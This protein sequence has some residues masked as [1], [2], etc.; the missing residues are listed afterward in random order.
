[1]TSWQTRVSWPA[2]TPFSSMRPW[3]SLFAVLAL[4]SSALAADL[5]A[6]LNNP[7]L[8][9]LSQTDFEKLPETRGF[10]WTSV[11]HDSAR[12]TKEKLFGLPVVEVIARFESGKLAALTSLFYGRGDEGG[13][14]EPQ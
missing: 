11:A 4:A 7:N 3:Y 13:I 14:P 1:M 8:W 12:A 5:D 10:S 9:T 6:L 2:R